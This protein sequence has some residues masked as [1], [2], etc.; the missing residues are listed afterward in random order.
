[1]RSDGFGDKRGLVLGEK[2]WE[3]GKSRLLSP[4]RL[5]SEEEVEVQIH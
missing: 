2:L 3:E 5:R 4:S 1:V